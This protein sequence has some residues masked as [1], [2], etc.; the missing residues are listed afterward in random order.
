MNWLRRKDR[1]ESP[2]A[3]APDH[4]VSG[5][6]ERPTRGIATLLS[7]VRSDRSHS[8]LDLGTAT[9]SSLQVYRGFAR[10][11]R[12][13]DLLP[14]ADE[15]DELESA[16]ASIPPHPEQPYDVLL[17]WNILDRVS[18][19]LRPQVI[20]RLAELSAPGARLY[21]AIESGPERPQHPLRF[22]L[23]DA[24][25]M[26]FEPMEGP[27]AAWPAL[28]PAEL[29]RLIEPFTV[30]RAFTTRVGIREYVAVLSG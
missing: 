25:H 21:L 14:V 11:V 15:E 18:P 4:P 1:P 9:N 13:G 26:W 28:L 19:T 20:A 24:E 22:G 6:I 17:A 2:T 7:G 29:E 10:W 5:R 16:L 3:P 27:P 23:V 30:S 8:V 12:F